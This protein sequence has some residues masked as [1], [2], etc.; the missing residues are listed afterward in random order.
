MSVF[1]KLC[2]VVLMMSLVPQ[3]VKSQEILNEDQ[4][5]RSIEVIKA[6]NTEENRYARQTY[7][8]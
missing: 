3:N 1:F 5:L 2:L 4:D 6:R 7:F 8:R